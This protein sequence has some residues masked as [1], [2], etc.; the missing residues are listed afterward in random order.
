M[1]DLHALFQAAGAGVDAQGELHWKPI[2]DETQALETRTP[3]AVWL[4]RHCIIDIVGPEAAVFLQNQIS[5]DVNALTDGTAQWQ[6]YTQPQGRLLAAFPLVRANAE[7][8][9]MMVPKDIA[10]ALH[11][12]LSMFVLRT[13]AKLSLSDDMLL[14]SINGALE[15]SVS[16]TSARQIKRLPLADTEAALPA[17]LNAMR[18]VS[19]NAWDL[20]AI[21][22][23]LIDIRS[24][25]QDTFIPQMLSW[26]KHAVNFKKGCYP[27]Q[28]V[29]AR[30]H[31]R[32]AVKRKLVRIMGTG[33]MPKPGDALE[34]EGTGGV[35]HIALAAH[36]TASGW[37]ALG[38]MLPE[39]RDTDSA[40]FVRFGQCTIAKLD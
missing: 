26:D 24:G 37:Q 7:H 6:G 25:A 2:A 33:E 9:W 21:R 34:V 20:Q 11:K 17:L 1:K 8:F 39:V 23:G 35:G 27:G 31:Y 12:R 32:G 15:G 3:V 5:N 19:A 30:A 36:S 22:E 40:V 18:F 28:E 4:E 14:G 10:L 38:N 29:V 16:L 13:K